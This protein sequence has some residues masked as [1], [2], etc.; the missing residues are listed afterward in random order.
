MKDQSQE[1]A[2]FYDGKSTTNEELVVQTIFLFLFLWSLSR[3][4]FLLESNLL[5]IDCIFIQLRESE[6]VG[7]S[8]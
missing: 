6:N 1:S 4:C 3:I 5:I 2:Q 8:W 7:W